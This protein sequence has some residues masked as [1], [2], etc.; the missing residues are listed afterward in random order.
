MCRK[1]SKRLDGE[2]RCRRYALPPHSK[3]GSRLLICSAVA[4]RSDDIAFA[5]AGVLWRVC[6]IEVFA[7][8]GVTDRITMKRIQ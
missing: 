7:Q 1:G 6:S 8:C 3:W 4:E 5:P 2:K